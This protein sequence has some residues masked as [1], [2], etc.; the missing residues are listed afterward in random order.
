MTGILG[1]GTNG[2]SNDLML[3][4]QGKILAD[5]GPVATVL[6]AK[7]QDADLFFSGTTKGFVMKD[8]NGNCWPFWVNT[9]GEISSTQVSCP[10]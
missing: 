5:T 4:Y 2:N 6:T 10:E 7:P 3:Q 8:A 1:N 9:A